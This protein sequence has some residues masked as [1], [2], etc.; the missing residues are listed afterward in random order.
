MTV[1]ISIWTVFRRAMTGFLANDGSAIAGYMAYA[2]LLALFPFLI[3]T[4]GLLGHLIGEQ[5]I[6]PTINLMFESMPQHVAMTLEPAL[7]DAVSKRHSGLASFSGLVAI[8]LASNGFGALRIALDRAYKTQHAKRFWYGKLVA[9]TFTLGGVIAFGV[10]TFCI[11]LAPAI[12]HW[13]DAWTQIDLENR[14]ML[15]WARYLI[16]TIVVTL[17]LLAIHWHLPSARPEGR[18][19]PGVI[20]T[21][22]LWVGLASLF[23]IYFSYAPSYAITYGTL[24]GVIVSLLFLYLT[25]AIFIFGAEIN[26]A[27]NRDEDDEDNKTE[28]VPLL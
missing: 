16:G 1:F 8:Y 25:S 27:M 10:L 6:N 28:R 4:T 18:K 19:W 24:A 7:R 13:I 14:G 2:G 12:I 20:V 15:H 26:A 21:T 23:S 3:F 17:F 11:V 5:G 9:F 22:I